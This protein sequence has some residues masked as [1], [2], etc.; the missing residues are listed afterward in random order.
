[1]SWLLPTPSPLSGQKALPGTHTKR[2]TKSGNLLLWEGGRKGWGTKSYKGEKAWSSLNRSILSGITFLGIPVHSFTCMWP[3]SPLSSHPC[4][5]PPPPTLFR[6]RLILSNL[7]CLFILHTVSFCL[8]S[9][10]SE[11]VFT[12]PNYR[13]MSPSVPALD[14]EPLCF[15]SN[16]ST[17]E[18][19]W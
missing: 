15:I 6:N 19:L 18:Y 14:S 3:F 7:L 12:I 17:T 1:M 10:R 5:S 8:C 4:S 16:S 9:A 13:S 2:L 11:L